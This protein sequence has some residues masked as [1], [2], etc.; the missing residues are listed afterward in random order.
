MKGKLIII[1][2]PSGSGKTT[3]VKKALASDDLSLKFSVSAC[4]RK[5][6]INET[7]GKDYYFLSA[8]EFRNKIENDEF[9]EWEEV[10]K[11]N[12]YGT[13]KSEVNRIWES[14]NNV[15][16]DVDVVGGLN[17]KR[18]YPEQSLS[19]FIQAPSVAELEKRLRNRSTDNEKTILKRVAKA[20]HEMSFAPQFDTII[21][22]DVLEDAVDE[23]HDSISSFLNA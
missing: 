9:I 1:S 15:I 13:L 12:Y 5:P 7:N 10:Y 18:Q 17:I 6:R 8:D 23:T 20:E 19:I 14:G 3:I 21:V 22:N 11:D 2:A 4:S 16:F